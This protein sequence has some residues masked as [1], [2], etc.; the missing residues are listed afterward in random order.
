MS[1]YF[2][3]FYNPLIEKNN[4]QKKAVNNIVRNSSGPV[5][6]IVF[7]P[8]GTGKT[9]TIVEAI[10]QLKHDKPMI[11]ILV[12]APANAACNVLA[13]K[14]SEFCEKDELIRVLSETVDM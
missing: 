11:K 6:Y 4:E 7:G 1:L 10:L 5:P 14:L 12:C 3:S 13:E 8:P 2:F 9:I